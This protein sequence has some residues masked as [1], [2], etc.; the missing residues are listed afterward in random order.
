MS[1]RRLSCLLNIIILL[2]NPRVLKISLRGHGAS[3][4]LLTLTYLL[5]LILLSHWHILRRYRS[6]SA[7]NQTWLSHCSPLIINWLL[8]KISIL[9]RRSI[10]HILPLNI[11]SSI[12]IWSQLLQIF[13]QR[14]LM[15][16][17]FLSHCKLNYTFKFLMIIFI[18]IQSLFKILNTFSIPIGI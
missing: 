9:H 2:T 17:F 11:A 7:L 13:C 14:Q 16:L 18:N 1:G 3:R 8:R 15:N 12:I 5:S 4:I 10:P 6:T